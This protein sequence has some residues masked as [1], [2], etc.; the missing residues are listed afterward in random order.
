MTIDNDPAGAR[1]LAEWIATRPDC[2]QKLAAE[3]PIGTKIDGVYVIGWTENDMIV[4]SPVHPRDDYNE[5]LR[6]RVH[7]C[8]AHLRNN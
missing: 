6:R 4:A 2:V 8:A 5:A 7:I 3:F 1:T